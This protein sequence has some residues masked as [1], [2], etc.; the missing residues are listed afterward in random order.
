VIPASSTATYA[1]GCS[2]KHDPGGQCEH[3]VVCLDCLPTA[4]AGSDRGWW[5]DHA[6]DCGLNLSTDGC[7]CE[8]SP[9]GVDLSEA[10]AA[11]LVRLTFAALV[12]TDDANHETSREL[13]EAAGYYTNACR[14]DTKWA[15]EQR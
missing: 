7:D 14:K 11:A 6:T 15:R 8:A 2:A 13:G 12:Y 10:K 1:H 5:G 3:G 9:V 4:C